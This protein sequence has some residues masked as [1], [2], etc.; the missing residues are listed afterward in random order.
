MLDLDHIPL[1]ITQK[2]IAIS[3]PVKNGELLPPQDVDAVEI[4]RLY[5]TFR[6][7]YVEAIRVA[8]E[9]GVRLRQKQ[10]SVGHGNWLRWLADNEAALGFG[11]RKAQRLIRLAE[12]GGPTLASDLTEKEAKQLTA[13]LWGHGNRGGGPSSIDKGKSEGRKALQARLPGLDS[14]AFMDATPEDRAKFFHGVGRTAALAAIPPE[15][16]VDVTVDRVLT[17][18][19]GASREARC[20]V[21]NQI[22]L[23]SILDA[24]PAWRGDLGDPPR[25]RRKTTTI[26]E[27]D[28]RAV[29][30]GASAE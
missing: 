12:K 13:E 29:P 20:G 8:A 11:E 4:G 22:G 30:P 24:V 14:L 28:F 5:R 21:L 18:W 1:P 6:A 23:P 9:A 2:S 15:W 25:P 16:S 7:S 26:I 3:D 19:Q 10:K 27:G 17:W